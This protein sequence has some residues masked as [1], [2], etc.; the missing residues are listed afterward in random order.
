MG[1]VYS[2]CA[3]EVE[4]IVLA[5]EHLQVLCCNSHMWYHCKCIVLVTYI[6]LEIV[7]TYVQS[8]T[9]YMQVQS[10]FSYM[11]VASCTSYIHANILLY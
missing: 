7:H 5:L 11:P 9:S 6:Q 3:T 10:R 2:L 4:R 8:C 1:L